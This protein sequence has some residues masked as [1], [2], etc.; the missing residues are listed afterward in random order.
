MKDIDA[1]YY[2]YRDD[3]DG[4]LIPLE[5][6]AEKIAVQNAIREWKEKQN[7]NSE[8]FDMADDNVNMPE[9][10]ENDPMSMLAPKFTAH[11]PVPSQKDIENAL[12][13]KKKLELLQKYGLSDN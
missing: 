13:Q 8:D 11:V 3:D 9:R 5:E 4:V 1:D 7:A 6:K 12:L 2:G 10:N